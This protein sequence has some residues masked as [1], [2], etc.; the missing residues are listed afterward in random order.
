MQFLKGCSVETNS[1]LPQLWATFYTMRHQTSISSCWAL[2][3][4][5]F[6]I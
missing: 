3:T 1:R 4:P 5:R 6:Y 2:C